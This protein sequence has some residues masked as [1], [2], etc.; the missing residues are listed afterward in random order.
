VC[1]SDLEEIARVDVL[2]GPFSAAY[3]GNSVGAVVDYQT[4]MPTQFEAHARVAGF[5][6][7]YDAY[8]TNQRFSGGQASASIGSR[9]GNFA[10][11]FNLSRQDSESHPLV[12][13]T[14][15]PST[16][17][18]AAGAT[19][20]TGAVAELNR[21]NQPWLLIGTTSQANTVQDH[22]KLKLAYRFTP[23]LRASYTLGWWDN[24]VQ[25]LP[26]SFL[27]DASGARIDI[28]PDNVP[29]TPGGTR[30]VSLDG[31]GVT[32]SAADFGRTRER[33][34][35][36]MHGVSLKQ[37]TGGSFDWEVA[38]SLY[39]YAKDEV[40]AWVPVAATASADSATIHWRAS[41]ASKCRAPSAAP[42]CRAC[43]AAARKASSAPCSAAMGRRNSATSGSTT[44]SRG[45]SASARRC[46]AEASSLRKPISRLLAPT[47]QNISSAP[48]ASA[49]QPMS[50]GP[51]GVSRALR[52]GPARPTSST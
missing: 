40:R 22:A 17:A 39:D 19:V 16:A 44:A 23:A 36:L 34:Q 31:R 13:V 4:R 52:P 29:A 38:A 5:T 42:P 15:T 51:G 6:Q 9:E 50:C 3:P 46:Q 21:F 14:R 24:T 35:H 45:T 37:S 25:R 48:S 49:S 26:E 28:R 33:L 30:A 7:R 27:Q 11:W 2:Y 43:A 20:V 41:V 1:S 10:W 12:Y 18:P 8:R 32:L 47:T